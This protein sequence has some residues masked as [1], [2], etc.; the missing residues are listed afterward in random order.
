M[1]S[2]RSLQARS[3]N[4]QGPMHDNKQSSGTLVCRQLVD[5][6]H[7]IQK[8]TS[9]GTP[10]HGKRGMLVRALAFWNAE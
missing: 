8:F 10:S 5:K 4:A 9:Q 2:L 3:R 1:K 6:D 7:A